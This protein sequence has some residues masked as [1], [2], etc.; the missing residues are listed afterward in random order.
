MFSARKKKKSYLCIS[1]SSK[2]DESPTCSLES[3]RQKQNKCCAESSWKSPPVD[4]PHSENK[5]ASCCSSYKASEEKKSI[6]TPWIQLECVSPQMTV[7]WKNKSERAPCINLVQ[8]PS[9]IP[10]TLAVLSL[11]LWWTHGNQ[12]EP[13]LVWFFKAVS[14]MFFFTT[15]SYLH[16]GA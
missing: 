2:A 11:T 5:S 9:V 3:L 12:G 15:Y 1:D 16:N 13:W 6:H 14:D 4:T 7:N 10:F 8:T